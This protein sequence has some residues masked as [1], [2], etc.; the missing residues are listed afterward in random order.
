[1]ARPANAPSDAQMPALASIQ[2]APGSFRTPGV[3]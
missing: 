2:R 1:M 3:S